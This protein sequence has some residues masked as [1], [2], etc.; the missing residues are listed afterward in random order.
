ME[1]FYLQLVVKSVVLLCDF[2]FLRSL[3]FHEAGVS[4]KAM[5]KREG[6]K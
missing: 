1:F 5:F 3:E 6:R 4:G 2:L